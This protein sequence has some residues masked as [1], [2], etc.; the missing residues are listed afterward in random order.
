[1]N[2]EDEKNVVALKI[3][4]KDELQYN[5]FSKVSKMSVV[6]DA[7]GK[8]ATVGNK[9]YNEQIL[10]YR[11]EKNK[12]MNDLQDVNSKIESLV[13]KYYDALMKHLEPTGN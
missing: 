2:G 3:L 4:L 5:D 9:V 13:D 1:M 7:L 10:N 11:E 6:E 8:L 12:L